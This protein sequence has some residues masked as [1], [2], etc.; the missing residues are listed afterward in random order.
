MR[1]ICLNLKWCNVID[2]LLVNKVPK[3]EAL[4]QIINVTSGLLCISNILFPARL[5]NE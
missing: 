5:R 4:K 3:D 2:V 1:N